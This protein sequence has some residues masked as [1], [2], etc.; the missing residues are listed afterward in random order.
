MTNHDETDILVLVTICELETIDGGYIPPTP[1]EIEI[2]C[3]G[4]PLEM[5]PVLF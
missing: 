4:L 3:H 5:C 1:E 2:F